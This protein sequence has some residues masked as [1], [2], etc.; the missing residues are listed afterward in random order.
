MKTMEEYL[1]EVARRELLTREEEQELLAAVQQKGT[2]CEEMTKLEDSNSSFIIAL[3]LQYKRPESSFEGFV[4]A[5]KNG[6][7]MAALQYK[8]ESCK[9]F[10]RF[11]VPF[12]REE[13]QKKLDL[14]K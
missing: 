5:G 8:P 6:L 10:I 12:I 11:A 14:S 3:S 1:K 4:N 2:D 9:S 7:R 13:M